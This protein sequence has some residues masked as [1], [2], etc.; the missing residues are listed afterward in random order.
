V[1]KFSVEVSLS[2]EWAWLTG[3]KLKPIMSAK[4][5]ACVKNK[6]LENE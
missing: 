4:M 3:T 1:K 2:H 6:N 5:A